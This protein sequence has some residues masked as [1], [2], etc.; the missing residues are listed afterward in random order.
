M[1]AQSRVNLEQVAQVCIQWGWLHNLSDQH[2]LVTN[3]KTIFFI[4]KWI[5]FSL[6][7]SSLP[8]V[9]SLTTTQR[10]GSS[11]LPSIRILYRLIRSLQA[12]A[13]LSAFPCM[14]ETQ[15]QLSSLWP[16][17]GLTPCLYLMSWGAQSCSLCSPPSAH[18]Q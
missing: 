12:F 2:V 4:V 16:L 6:N 9:L 15:M 8:L 18:W 3:C 10:P 17:T 11:L 1:P 7:F 5:F 13:A 14:A